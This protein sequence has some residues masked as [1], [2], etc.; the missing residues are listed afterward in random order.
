MKKKLNKILLAILIISTIIAGFRVYSAY[1]D[2]LM[3]KP[4]NYENRW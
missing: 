4:F 2:Y 1:P 3:K